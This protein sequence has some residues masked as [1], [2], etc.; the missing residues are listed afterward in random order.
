MYEWNYTASC[1]AIN[2]GKGNFEIQEL[3][4]YAQ[5]SCIN[6]VLCADI[7]GDGRKDLI[8][9]GNQFHFQ[10]QF[11][12]LDASYGH[13]LLNKGSDKAKILWE[14][15][16]SSVTGFEVSGEIKDVF[17]IPS[18]KGSNLLV[19]QNDNYPALFR[20]TNK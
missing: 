11:A 18:A 4:V 6:A 12:R 14:W 9:G 16:E 19:L 13:I 8:M 1:V 10:P 20:R 15:A 3:P 7:N 17:L 5:L 2:T